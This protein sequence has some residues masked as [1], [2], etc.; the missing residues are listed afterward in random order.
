MDMVPGGAP[1]VVRCSSPDKAKAKRSY[2]PVSCIACKKC[3]KECPEDAIHV[4]DFCAKVDYEKC[5]GCGTCVSVC[6]QDCID[7]YGREAPVAASDADGMG[8]DVPG[9][10][11]DV[12]SGS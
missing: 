8:A 6:P 9:F 2:C 1:V 7:L 5:T 12:A 3:E 11:P 4:I 10:E